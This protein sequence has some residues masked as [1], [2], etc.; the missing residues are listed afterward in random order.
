MGG[1]PEGPEAN[2]QSLYLGTC[3]ALLPVMNS[4]FPEL[5]VNRAH[6]RETTWLQSVVF[7]FLGADANVEDLLRR[8]SSGDAVFNKATSDYVRQAISRDK[9]TEIVTGWLARRMPG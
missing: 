8:T 3:D 4:R 1:P 2:F 7:M 6:C 5:G 9:W